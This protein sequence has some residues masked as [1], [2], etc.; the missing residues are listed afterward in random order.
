MTIRPSPRP[1]RLG[2]LRDFRW[3]WLV[4]LAGFIVQ[5]CDPLDGGAGWVTAGAAPRPAPVAKQDPA[6][7]E[8]EL[9]KPLAADGL[10]DPSNPALSLLQEPKEAL[11][12]LPRANDGNNVDWVQ[13]LEDGYI[14][15]R[16]NIYPETKIQVLDLNILLEDTAG[17]PMVLFP[18]RQHTEW[19]DCK[20]CHDRI[21]KA[22]RGAN[23]FGMLDILQGNFCGQ[24]HGA[25]S[26]PLTQCT[27]CHSVPR[28]DRTPPAGAAG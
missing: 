2:N 10:H 16:T 12:E 27:R 21:F 4:L 26:F 22:K 18:H 14:E 3:A 6:L 9:W 23:K 28:T 7:P 17:M 24:C 1:A 19:L 5:G 20:N 11:S 13:A 8:P 15:P 25:V